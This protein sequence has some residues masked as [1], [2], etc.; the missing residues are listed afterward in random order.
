MSA[1]ELIVTGGS[2]R[3]A[4][5][6]ALSGWFKT[7]EGLPETTERVYYDTFDGLLY[8]AGLTVWL[9]RGELVLSRRDGTGEPVVEPF[10]DGAP[11]PL[12]LEA[13]MPGPLRAALAPVVGVRVLL[14]IARVQMSLESDAVLDELQKTVVRLVLECPQ[15]G[16][17][18]RVRVLP[19]RGY[20]REGNQIAEL[21]LDSPRIGRAELPLVDEAVISRGGDP[22]GVGSGTD[23][24]F[25]PDEPADAVVARVLLA[26]TE[27]R[28]ANL[29]GLLDDLDIEFLHDYRVALRRSRAVVRELKGV[30]P[31]GRIDWLRSELR[32]L[33]RVT[34]ESR[35][36]D[37]YL[38]EFED[39]RAL[40]PESMRGDLAPLHDVLRERHTAAR[41]AMVTALT[42]PRAA[43]LQE[44][45]VGL[46]ETLPS[47][48]PGDRPACGE[49]IGML[50]G[51]SI[52][53]LHRR[54]VKMG[55]SIDESSPPQDYHELRKQG[56]EL[57]YMLELFGR[58]LAEP[59]ARSLIRALKALQDV[60]G[61]HQDR[62]VQIEMLRSMAGQV[63]ARPGGEAALMAMGG[64]VERLEEEAA[65]A[66]A[67]FHKR[68]V[69]FSSAE[70]RRLV[71]DTFAR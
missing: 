30:F 5:H 35:D 18:D 45:F 27:V 51:A 49:P 59:Q 8:G 68:F 52:R 37:V 7:V 56:K 42:G 10:D 26:L 71:K 70:Q 15:G 29:P 22:A 34:G 1:A 65:G 33:Q 46:L 54:I 57:R 60:L 67:E 40:T 50:A 69:E 53:K 62:E 11:S 43:G 12:H 55:R 17:R 47:L 21:L 63:G 20:R 58:R 44:R 23:V 9:E 28:A 13:L 14:E 66:R 16:L 39:L 25:D 64:M 6:D 32:W 3:A 31:A 4:V 24:A 61:R 2:A 41:M 48:P 19:L 38:H 36:L